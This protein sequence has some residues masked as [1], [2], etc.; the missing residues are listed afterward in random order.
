MATAS[1]FLSDHDQTGGAPKRR[2]RPPPGQ[3]LANDHTRIL[4]KL[5]QNLVFMFHD[6][7]PRH[8]RPG[9]GIA[10]PVLSLPDENLFMERQ[11]YPLC[12]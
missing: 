2:T 7:S 11:W 1:L 8:I 9:L 3:H 6:R 12:L 5:S 10:Q 4:Y